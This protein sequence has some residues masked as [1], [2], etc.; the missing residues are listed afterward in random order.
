M[1]Y[2]KS[3]FWMSIVLNLLIIPMSYFIGVMG[4]DSA[5]S[6]AEMWQGFLFG[7]LFVQGIPLLLLLTSIVM[8]VLRKKIKRKRLKIGTTI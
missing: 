8:I 6:D 5:S 3:F 2:S 7:F 1:S 4:T